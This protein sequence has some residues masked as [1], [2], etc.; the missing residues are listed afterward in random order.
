MRWTP[1]SAGDTGIDSPSHRIGVHGEYLSVETHTYLDFTWIWVEDDIDGDVESVAVTF[2]SRSGGT[3]I[4]LRHTGPWTTREP[5]DSYR[6]GWDHVFD[7]LAEV[8]R[9]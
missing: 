4:D 1:E 5:V 8:S 2:T 9:S 6:Q 7:S 3:Q